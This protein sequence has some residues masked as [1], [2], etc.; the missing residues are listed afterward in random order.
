MPNREELKRQNL[1]SRLTQYTKLFIH[2][3]YLFSNF[4]RKREFQ[5]DIKP[6]HILHEISSYVFMR[7]NTYN[8]WN[9]F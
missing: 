9:P 4:S 1:T 2:K 6:Y 7:N 8:A 3:F 5:A